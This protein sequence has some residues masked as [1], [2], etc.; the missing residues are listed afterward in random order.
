MILSTFKNIILEVT[1]KTKIYNIIQQTNTANN[2]VPNIFKNLF[3]N[4]LF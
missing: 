1:K 2:V 3:I 4:I